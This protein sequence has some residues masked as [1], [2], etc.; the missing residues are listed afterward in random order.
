VQFN[1]PGTM[2]S[3]PAYDLL[4]GIAVLFYLY[5]TRLHIKISSYVIPYIIKLS[6][7]LM[8]LFFLTVASIIFGGFIYNDKILLRDL[9]SA[10]IYLRLA[11]YIFVGAV[12][13]YNVSENKRPYPHR[14]SKIV[15]I[16]S[17]C[18][19]VGISIL[20]YM[21]YQS[22]HIP[23][24]TQFALS[25]MDMEKYSHV[26]VVGVAGNP[27]WNSLDLNIMS[28]VLFSMLIISLYRRNICRSILLGTLIVILSSLILVGYSRTGILSCFFLLVLFMLF[29]IKHLKGFSIKSKAF[30]VIGITLVLLA[31]IVVGINTYNHHTNMFQKRIAS[32]LKVD[33]FGQRAF[34]WAERTETGMDRFPLGIGPSRSELSS[35][36]DSEFVSV[37]GNSGALGLIIYGFIMLFLIVKPLSL[38][39]GKLPIES[40]AV[41]YS[42][43]AIGILAMCYSLTA[44]FARNLRASSLVFLLHSFL[45]CQVIVS[46]K[47]RM[48]FFVR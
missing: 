46:S 13:A 32:T 44:D 1:I 39:R 31:F 14:I 35:T 3:L 36:V 23:F 30:S 45:C 47:K 34:L 4:I 15:I 41:L 48:M 27:N 37:L 6:V 12:L 5:G 28:S 10:L 11:F 20:Q 8:I 33:E 29:V 38:S 25:Y 17:L 24:L 7:G 40:Y 43:A 2:I 42:V 16:F 26:R 21:A 22:I 9:N 19:L 18:Y